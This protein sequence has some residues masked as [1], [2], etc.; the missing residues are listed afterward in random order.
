MATKLFVGN[1]PYEATDQ[2]LTELF[3]QSGTVV[4]ASV[5]INKFNNRSKGFGFVEMSTQEE[6][7][8]AIET[9]NGQEMGGRRIIVSEARPREERPAGGGFR[10]GGSRG[11]YDSGGSRGGYDR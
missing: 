8:A 6:A 2:S 5:V 11:G 3:S 10:S 7:N 4:S 1:L 9:L